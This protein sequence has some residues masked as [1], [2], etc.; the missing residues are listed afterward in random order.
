MQ[1]D[2]LRRALRASA[3]QTAAT[4]RA[5]LGLSQ[6]SLSRAI[7]SLEPDV[8]MVGRAR[9]TTYALRRRIEDVPREIPLYEV[10]DGVR[11]LA[12]LHPV[13]PRG[14]YVEAQVPDAQSGWFDD[15]PWFM[16][17]LRPQGYLGRMLPTRHPD[18]GHPSDVRLWSSDQVL[19]YLVAHGWDG[20]GAIIAGDRALAAFH[21]AMLQPPPSGDRAERYTALATDTLRQGPAGSSAAG[22]HP[23]FLTRRN[24]GVGVLVKFSPRR[25]SPVPVRI[26]DLLI[27]EHHALEALR[28]AGIPAAVSE[29]VEAD[30][31]VFLEVERFDRRGWAR[32]G[33]VALEAVDAFHVGRL[34]SWSDSADA[35]GAR[36]SAGDRSRIRWL[37]LFGQTIGNTDMHMANLAFYLRGTTLDGV[38]PAYDM[39]PAVFAPRGAELPAAAFV[40]PLAGPADAAIAEAVVE[41][42][43]WFWQAVS[44]D[45]RVSA[46]FRGIASRSGNAVAALR[47]R[48]HWLPR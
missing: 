43:E 31:R 32:R 20:P 23:K 1:N 42:A 5:T 16:H 14:L 4:L 48:L 28:A 15:L 3:P 34:Q 44:T 38:A 22:E 45:E 29:V 11:R 9:A 18:L 2:D 8:L 27:A 46:D 30:G 40:P 19:R 25:E 41:A 47:P 24:D 35:L 37:H 26:A 21:E 6:P 13:A 10:G 7:R 17:D 12:I 33:V 39:L 36:I